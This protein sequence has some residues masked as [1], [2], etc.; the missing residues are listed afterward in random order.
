MPRIIVA[1]RLLRLTALVLAGGLSACASSRPVTGPNLADASR[2]PGITCAPFARELAGI[3]L[4]GDAYSWWTSASGR[5]GRSAQP[6]IGAVLVLRRNSRLPSGHVAV[7]SR[8]LAP[9]Q[10]LVIQ[11]N[12]VP[13]ELTEDQLAVDVSPHNDW[14]EVR[15]WWPPTNALGDHAF[16]AYGFILPPTPT[17]HDTL[18]R[19]ARP[20]AQLAL[21][22][23]SGRPPPRA[24]GL[25]G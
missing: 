23:G 12:W 11:A 18:R 25:G 17:T 15:M 19:T 20:A 16:P 14:T 1:L 21:N 4:Y 8:V 6:E 22:A 3:A 10:V 13:D 24:R 9:R 2:H 7:V 5:Y